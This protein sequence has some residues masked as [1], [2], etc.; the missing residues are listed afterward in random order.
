MKNTRIST[1]NKLPH[2]ARLPKLILKRRN[3]IHLSIKRLILTILKIKYNS[4][5]KGTLVLSH[6]AI[7][8]Q[9]LWPE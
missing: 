9:K 5:N 4:E 3:M 6:L 2:K 7:Q 1:V 8:T